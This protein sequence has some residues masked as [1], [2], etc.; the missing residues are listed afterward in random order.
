LIAYGCST[1]LI[2]V[3][4]RRNWSSDLTTILSAAVIL[5]FYV[6]ASWLDGTLLWPLTGQFLTGLLAAYG[7]QQ[8]AYN[9]FS[10]NALGDPLRKVEQ[11][12]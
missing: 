9:F 5:I 12:T 3:I 4:R 6:L 8:G 10:L 2:A 11:A 1:F 7:T